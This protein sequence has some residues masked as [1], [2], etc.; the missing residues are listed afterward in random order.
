MRIGQCAGL[1][2]NCG[3]RQ[4]SIQGV[5]PDAR[6]ALPEAR[7][8]VKDRRL[9][10][11]HTFAAR[12]PLR[13]TIRVPG[14]KSISHRSLMFAGLAVGRS[15]ITGLLEGEDVLATAAAMRQ[16]GA[17]I[18]REGDGSWVVDGVGVGSLLEP[19]EALDMGNSGTST[20]LLMGLVAGHAISATFTGDASLSGRPMNRVIVPL[21]QMGASIEASAG[22]T[23]PLML[24]GAN[25]A[26]PITYRL[27]VA[28]AQVKSA[29]LLAGLNTPGITRVIEPVPTRDHTERMLTG[30]GAKLEVG[31]ENGETVIA[32]HGEAELKPMDVIVPGDPS[33]AAF[34]MVAA[35]IVPGSDLT[36]LNVGLNPTRA[37]LLHVL[38]QM[39][40][41]I[42]EVDARE[43]GG[44]PVADLRVRHAPLSGI[45]V[46]PAIAPSMIDEFPVLFVAAALASGTTRTTG[47]EELRVKESDRLAAMAAALTAAGARVEELE[48]GLTIHGTGG[49]PL[50]G[51]ANGRVKS[52]LDHRIAMSMAVAG[53]VSE[54]GVEV[55]DIAPINTSFPTFMGLLDEATG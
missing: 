38:R 36:I 10:S 20:R 52:L 24:R 44:E 15:R 11:S 45:D 51:T 46:D 35:S 30:F 6:R 17:Q 26:V 42:E 55:D 28:S 34:F 9:M 49:E 37:G 8:A 13:G 29:I 27:P 21:S 19:R 53:L 32:I 2:E 50:R 23:L 5:R 48:D 3:F 4:A 33:S 39:G 43:V 25:P 41:D 16:F 40:A 14:D 12:G 22:G 31:E 1:N 47:L 7:G 54:G 18:A